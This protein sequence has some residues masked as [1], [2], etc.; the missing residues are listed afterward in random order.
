[1]N[2]VLQGHDTNE[3]NSVTAKSLSRGR[4][5]VLSKLLSS[6]SAEDACFRLYTPFTTTPWRRQCLHTATSLEVGRLGVSSAT[7]SLMLRA[8]SI[9]WG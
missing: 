9:C 1:M 6:S 8:L 5:W 2:K 3:M 4:S 7:E